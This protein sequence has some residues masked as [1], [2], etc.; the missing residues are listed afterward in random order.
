MPR[1]KSMK[2][3]FCTFLSLSAFSLTASA[4]EINAGQSTATIYGFAK[5]N[6][7]YDVD[8]RLGT[9]VTHKGIAL[10]MRMSPKAILS[11]MHRIADW[12]SKFLPTLLVELSPP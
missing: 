12:E 4:I 10:M 11:L 1:I 2:K 5:L 6:M 9:F 3:R 7:I 8:A